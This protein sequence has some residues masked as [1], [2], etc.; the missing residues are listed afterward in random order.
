MNTPRCCDTIGV[1]LLYE[2]HGHKV[3]GLQGICA[4]AAIGPYS[5]LNPLNCAV[6]DEM[7]RGL[8]RGV[9][10]IEPSA[11][12]GVEHSEDA[13]YC[14]MISRPEWTA[15]GLGAAGAKS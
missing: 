2:D 13:G 3:T 9:K 4:L 6:N 7:V 14:L 15:D 12:G 5:G 11:F 1:L 8:I 10:Q